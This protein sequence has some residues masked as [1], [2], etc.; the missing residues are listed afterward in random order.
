MD[1]LEK[2]TNNISFRES[3]N[4]FTIYIYIY[5]LRVCRTLLIQRADSY[6]VRLSRR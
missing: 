1:V 2:L 3:F 6:R 4:R 5:V